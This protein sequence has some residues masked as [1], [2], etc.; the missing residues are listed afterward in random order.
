[1]RNP[2]RE[3]MIWLAVF[4][5][6]GLLIL[7]AFRW[8]ERGHTLWV[9][10]ALFFAGFMM[11]IISPLAAIQGLLGG[12]GRAKLIAGRDVIARWQVSAADWERFRAFD[13]GRALAGLP[14]EVRF[15]EQSPAHGAEIIVG[16][17][18]VL[19]GGSYHPLRRWALP[20]LERVDWL[21]NP[22]GPSVLEFTVLYG[23]RS[24]VT[25][26]GIRLPVPDEAEANARR[27]YDHYAV[28]V[29][30]PRP[31]PIARL[32][33]RQ[34]T[35]GLAVGTPVSLAAFA[36]GWWLKRGGGEGALPAILMMTG[37]TALFCLAILGIV[38]LAIRR[39]LRR[40]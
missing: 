1:M 2:F 16:K 39:A 5:A 28:A 7:T 17:R 33:P 38:Y 22:S 30:P 34:A 9:G 35:L 10:L 20:E 40:A 25:R 12:R 31:A 11:V 8:L 3:G 19:V 32:T 26:L 13:A 15:S 4:A 36:A 29:P 6:G 21:A 27:V 23:G 37:I 18:S 14:S 24:G